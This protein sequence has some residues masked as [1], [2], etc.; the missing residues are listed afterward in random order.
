MFCKEPQIIKGRAV[1]KSSVY[2]PASQFQ[3]NSI[4]FED[5]LKLIVFFFYF[6]IRKPVIAFYLP[7]SP[8]FRGTKKREQTIAEELALV[9][10]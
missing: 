1:E 6:W 8:P 3:S 4:K 9:E 10:A 7:L 2:F 5:A